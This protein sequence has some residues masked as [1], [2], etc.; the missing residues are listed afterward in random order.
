MMNSL[1]LK[2]LKLKLSSIL[3]S[4]GAQR[5]W[6]T[7][8]LHTYPLSINLLTWKAN[9]LL[10]DIRASHPAQCQGL[11]NIQPSVNSSCVASYSD[12]GVASLKKFRVREVRK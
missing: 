10:L 3:S 2:H 4:C 6:R 12:Y 5:E 11:S 7:F 8:R 9:F 1:E